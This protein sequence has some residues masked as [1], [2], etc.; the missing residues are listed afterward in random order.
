MLKKLMIVAL[1]LLLPAGYALADNDVGCGAGTQIWEGQS[2]T[3]PKLLA[4]TTNQSFGSQTFGISSGTLGCSRNGTVT[5]ANRLPMFASANMGSLASDMAAGH[6]QALSTMADLYGIHRGADKQAFY[7]MTQRHFAQIF[8][9]DA[10][11]AGQVIEHV[12]HLMANDPQL[13]S[14]VKA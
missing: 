1:M 11:T 6:G 2:G 10:V 7:H 13:A 5:A 8:S 3:A 4:A 12:N 14:Y 9:S